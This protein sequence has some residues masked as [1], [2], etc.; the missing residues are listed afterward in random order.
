MTAI[1]KVPFFLTFKFDIN[2]FILLK[3]FYAALTAVCIAKMIISTR[4]Q[5]LAT[6]NV[7][8]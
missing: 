3:T 7:F 5:N 2:V 6:L 1:K 4:L 8:R